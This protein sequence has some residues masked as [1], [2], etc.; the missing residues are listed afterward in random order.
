MR[1][2]HTPTASVIAFYIFLVMIF[3]F[4]VIFKNQEL[5]NKNMVILAFLLFF[6]SFTHPEE[7]LY[8]LVVFLFVDF[9]T[10]YLKKKI[11]RMVKYLVIQ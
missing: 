5:S 3:F 9:S 2:G 1:L 11:Y 8:F 6:L 10:F 7:A 4:Y